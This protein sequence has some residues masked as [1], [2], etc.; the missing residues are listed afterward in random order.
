M[1]LDANGDGVGGDDFFLDF[2]RLAGDADGDMK[3]DQTD[4]NIVNAALGAIPSSATWNANADLDRDGRI[5]V[6]DR[7]IVARSDGNVITPPAIEIASAVIVLPGDYNGN[8]V[9]DAADYAVWRNNAGQTSAF[10]PLQGDGDFDGDVDM[11]DYLV[12]KSNYGLNFAT[13][14]ARIGAPKVESISAEVAASRLAIASSIEF[15]GV[16][17]MAGADSQS[18]SGI[19]E[20]APKTDRGSAHDEVFATSIFDGNVTLPGTLRHKMVRRPSTTSLVN[21]RATELLSADFRNGSVLTSSFD[22]PSRQRPTEHSP[23][24]RSRFNCVDEAF[25]QEFVRDAISDDSELPSL[26]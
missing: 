13:Y 16:N 4:M 22:D 12:W 23:D 3:V 24:R 20:T 14:F 6:R 19:T 10:R 1:P 17:Q 11:A 7:L 2:H 25:S 15:P 26:R 21:S 5:T 9:V 8:N 18:P